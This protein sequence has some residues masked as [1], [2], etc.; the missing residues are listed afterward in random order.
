MAELRADI[1]SCWQATVTQPADESWGEA[2]PGQATRGL[3]LSPTLGCVLSDNLTPL[4][5]GL[6][7]R[8]QELRNVHEAHMST[9][10]TIASSTKH[11]RLGAGGRLWKL[12]P[13][14]K[15][16]LLLR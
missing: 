3:A 7:V 5:C 16:K 12:S 14:E 8:M 4:W 11:L 1:M 2:R 6:L 9:F 15:V 10:K 13:I